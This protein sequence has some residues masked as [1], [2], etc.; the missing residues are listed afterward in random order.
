[1]VANP[2]APSAQ[3]GKPLWKRPWFWIVAAPVAGFLFIVTLGLVAT[4]AVPHVLQKFAVASRGKCRLD[5]IAIRDAC[6]EYAIA[7]GGKFP[8]SLQSLLIPDVNGRKYLDT[9][10][11]PKDPWG[12]PYLYDPPGPGRPRPIIQSLG[13]DGQLGGEG[14]DAD[15]D[16]ESLGETK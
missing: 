1:M 4:F 8:P 9:T 13:R 16:S 15:L 2:T 14:D 5:I 12:R 10:S 7:N 11:T 6:T 3:I